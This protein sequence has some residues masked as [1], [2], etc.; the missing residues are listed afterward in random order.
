MHE[1]VQI[2]LFKY[3]LEGIS[4]D[5][6]R[7]LPVPSINSLI[8]FHATFNSFCK[9]YFP[10]EHLFEGCCNEFS[11]LHKDYV[12]HESL[13]CDEE[14]IVEEKIYHEDHVVLN[15][16]HYDRN[17]IEKFGIISDV[18]VVLNIHEYQHISF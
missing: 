9:E 12:G 13:I 17:N 11:L 6:C 15:D 14:S 16:I 8:D 5:W 2:K 3:S 1:D 10:T 7:S 4:R 18:S